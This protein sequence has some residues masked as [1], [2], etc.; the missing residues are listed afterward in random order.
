[1]VER[2]GTTMVLPRLDAIIERSGGMASDV[3]VTALP[4]ADPAPAQALH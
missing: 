1:M 2:R 3:D 4:V